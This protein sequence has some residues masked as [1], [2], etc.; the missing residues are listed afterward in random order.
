MG[1]VKRGLRS[2]TPPTKTYAELAEYW[3][4][5][6]VPQKRSGHHDE[7]IIRAHLRPFYGP[8]LVRDI[9]V[10]DGDR[11]QLEK[12]DGT[13]DKK[14]LD[15]KTINNHLTLRTAQLNLAYELGWIPRGC[16]SS[17]SRRSGSSPRRLSSTCARR[18]RFRRVLKLPP[19]RQASR[20]GPLRDRC[21]HRQSRGR[22]RRAHLGRR[23]LRQPLI[24]V[25][26]IFEGPTR[27]GTS[28][29]SD[30]RRA[31]SHPS[32]LALR[33]PRQALFTNQNGRM[34]C[35]SSRVF[36]EDLH[37]SCGRRV[38]NVAARQGAPLPTG[39]HDFR[40]TFACHWIMDGGDIFKLQKNPRPQGPQDDD[41]V[42]ASRAGRVRR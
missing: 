40:H 3:V 31:A 35:Q 10:A 30:P 28:G 20:L 17:G 29:R 38:P 36:Q 25:Q 22:A 24:T 12:S 19:R 8:M 4:T 27:P 11:Y 39:F 7:S 5:F 26:R 34:Q 1:D 2:P 6:R 15:R 14:P 32:P 41:A 33:S 21:V 42:R 13:A 23:R 9:G 18:T 37:R 16:R